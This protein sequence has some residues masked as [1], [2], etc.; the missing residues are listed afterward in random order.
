MKKYRII[1]DVEV[2]RTTYYAEADCVIVSRDEDDTLIDC[3]GRIIGHPAG[4]FP[5]TGEPFWEDQDGN[6]LILEPFH[7]DS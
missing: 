4:V 1:G 3:E 6:M 2:S 5:P 7:L